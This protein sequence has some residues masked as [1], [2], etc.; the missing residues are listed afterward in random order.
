M[1]ATAPLAAD[2]F[3][4]DFE[5]FLSA[6]R[7]PAA[8]T[9]LRRAGLERFERLGFPTTRREHWRFTDLSALA[10]IRFEK[11]AGVPVDSDRLPPAL[12]KAAHRLVFVNGFYTP[13]LSKVGRLPPGVVVSSLAEALWTRP[14]V[15]EKHLGRLPALE[16]HPF[17]AL[18]DAFFEDGAF[19]HLPR[20]TVLQEPLQLVFYAAGDDTVN[21]PRSLIVLEEAAQAG[22][23]AEYRGEG[24]YLA[25]PL[26]EIA[27]AAEAVLE[28]HLIQQED[29]AARHL[30]GLSLRQGQAS[31]VNVHLFC[32]DGLLVR[33]DV[34]AVL[35]GEGA[36]CTLNGL[37]LVADGQLADQHL[38][39]EHARPHGTSRQLFKNVLEGKSRAVFNGMIDVRQDAQKTDASQNN[40]NLLLSRRAL[41]NSN[42]RLEILADDVKCTH[43]STVGFLDPEALFY[44]RTRGIGEA[45]ARAMLA[46]AFANDVIERIRLASLRE[47]LE[48]RLVGRLY[49][50]ATER[51]SS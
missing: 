25:C 24:R 16:D 36:G 35:D 19:V 32:D 33:T 14:E 44:L 39:I 2:A 12:D 6:R 29:G 5:R 10:A 23:V 30:G 45:E 50:D 48:Q 21:Y 9:A 47:R 37:S 4:A 8:L 7:E 22:V 1:A 38:R 3:G 34:N 40:R 18:N 31:Q 26:T 43:G 15:I 51:L 28:Y 20:G 27:A 17:S 49:P 46:Y 42:P 11:S 13:G 41:A